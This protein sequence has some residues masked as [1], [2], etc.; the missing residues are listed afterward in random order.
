MKKGPK[1]ES[2]SLEQPIYRHWT[3]NTS[4]IVVWYRRLSGLCARSPSCLWRG[5]KGST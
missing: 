4:L 1:W 3:Y 2:F 5:A